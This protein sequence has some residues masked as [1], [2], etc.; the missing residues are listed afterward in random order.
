MEWFHILETSFNPPRNIK[1]V[2][3]T[4][5]CKERPVAADRRDVAKAVTA[6]GTV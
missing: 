1:F 4:K 3:P 5:E 6:F 2:V